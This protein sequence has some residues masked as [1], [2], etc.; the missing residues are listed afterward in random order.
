MPELNGIDAAERIVQ[1][2]PETRVI[3][4]STHAGDQ[5]VARALKAGARGYILK[6]A[7]PAELQRA[8]A[9][10]TAGKTYLSPTVVSQIV[11]ALAQGKP[12]EST[13]LEKLTPRQRQVLQLVAEGYRTKEIAKKLGISVRTVENH[14]AQIMELLDIHDVVGLVHFALRAGLV[15][16]KT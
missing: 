12:A 1:E 14:R 2:Y 4:L 6:D 16:A 3:I 5:Y 13:P 15:Q 9:A 8:L 7:E 10:V 11:T